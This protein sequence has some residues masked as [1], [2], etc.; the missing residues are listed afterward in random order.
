MF[1]SADAKADIKKQTIWLIV[2]MILVFAAST[3]IGFIVN[4]TEDI[5]LGNSLTINADGSAKRVSDYD[6]DG[7]NDWDDTKGSGMPDIL[8]PA[9]MDPKYYE[10][11]IKD[12]PDD[13]KYK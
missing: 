4:V 12:H 13:P 3:I 1:A 11:W 6:G 7:I 5:T 2:G 8:N 10:Q 9:V